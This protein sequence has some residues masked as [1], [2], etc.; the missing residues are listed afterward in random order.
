[1]QRSAASDLNVVVNPDNPDSARISVG[2]ER[3]VALDKR[4]FA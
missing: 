3:A 2:P 4:L 1:V